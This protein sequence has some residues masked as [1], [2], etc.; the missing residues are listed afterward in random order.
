M[1]TQKGYTYKTSKRIRNWT[2]NDT[3]RRV[4]RD[5]VAR[6]L[7]QVTYVVNEQFWLMFSP[8]AIEAL[9][10]VVFAVRDSMQHQI[11][12]HGRLSNGLTSL[13]D[14]VRRLLPV[15]EF[16][17]AYLHLIAT[18]PVEACSDCL[19]SVQCSNAREEDAV[20][21]HIDPNL[22]FV[23]A[24]VLGSASHDVVPRYFT[25][26]HPAQSPPRC[27]DD[28]LRVIVRS[29]HTA[30]A[31]F[32]MIAATETGDI[33]AIMPHISA[34]LCSHVPPRL[35][36]CCFRV[37]VR[38]CEHAA[39]MPRVAGLVSHAIERG[40]G[41]RVCSLKDDDTILNFRMLLLL[42]ARQ[43]PDNVAALVG[44]MM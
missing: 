13:F 15:P 18:L 9:C 30:A 28:V 22:D 35:L 19:Y 10:G 17:S 16:M 37:L 2:R 29:S 12:V 23:F 41:A 39:L 3:V 1:M 5:I 32:D 24:G 7:H 11:L 20:P 42:V 44:E 33:E 21:S 14:V 43:H 27:A 26:R 25:T 40:L 8:D 6:M 34:I 4:A 38:C 31:F 36:Q